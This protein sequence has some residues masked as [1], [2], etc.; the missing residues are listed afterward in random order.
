MLRARDVVRLHMGHFTAPPSL[1][2]IAGAAV[3]V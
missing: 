2:A 3:V 1:P